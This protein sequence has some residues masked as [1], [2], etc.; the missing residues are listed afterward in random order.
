MHIANPIYD[1]VFKYL[2]EDNKVA[3]LLL[4]AIIGEHITELE[5]SAQERTVEVKRE[6]KKENDQ[7][8]TFTVCRFDFAAKIQTE[9]G[10]KSI[11]IELQKAKLLT[12][13]MRFRRYLGLHYQNTNNTYEVA[14]TKKDNTSE[15][16][17]GEKIEKPRQIYCIYFLAYGMD[18]P[19]CPVLKVDY[20]VQDIYNGEEYPSNG[21]F[22]SGLHHRSWIVQINQLKNN[23]R[24]NLEKVLAVFDQSA[25]IDFQKH[26][27]DV[28]EEEFP[29]DYRQIIRR[30]RKAMEDPEK[31]RAMELEDEILNELKEAE[32]KIEA[33]QAQAKAAQ[34][35]VKAERDAKEV[36]EA[37]AEVAEAKAKNAKAEVAKKLLK[38]GMTI[39]Q[40]AE[41]TDLSKQEIN[42][43]IQTVN[44]ENNF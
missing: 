2:L 10:F 33:A 3:K 15:T 12:D 30:L 22:I 6:S 32:R 18:L 4:S 35:Q 14:V 37:K 7:Q 21:E 34:A 39:E 17:D 24:N 43:V 42:H 29:E 20:K 31:R 40:V 28:D 38:S 16:N 13:L 8:A 9:T 41:M 1:V 19:P 26:I 25:I 23:R 36:A 11:G 5:F 27:V 44:Q